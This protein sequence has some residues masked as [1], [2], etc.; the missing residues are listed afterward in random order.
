MTANLSS[1]QLLAEVPAN[2]D[3]RYVNVKFFG[4]RR[5]PVAAGVLKAEVQTT[6]AANKYLQRWRKCL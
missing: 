6:I 3:R 5:L 1:P 2:G 4:R